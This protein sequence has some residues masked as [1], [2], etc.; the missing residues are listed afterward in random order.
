MGSS[1]VTRL[2]KRAQDVE[3]AADV[4][5]FQNGATYYF[6][7]FYVW[8]DDVEASRKVLGRVLALHRLM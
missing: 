4:L 1:S 3:Q 2:S 8:K 7:Y 5:A 6:T